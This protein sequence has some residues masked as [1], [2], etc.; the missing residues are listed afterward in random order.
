MDFYRVRGAP[1]CQLSGGERGALGGK[2]GEVI[3]GI[4]AFWKYQRMMLSP[5]LCKVC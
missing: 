2:A 1:G 3:Y 4:L 5:A